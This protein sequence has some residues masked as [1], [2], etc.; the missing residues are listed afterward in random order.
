MNMYHF[1]LSDLNKESKYVGPEGTKN[2][3]D[4][5]SRE[6]FDKK[7]TFFCSDIVLSKQSSTSGRYFH[8]DNENS[9]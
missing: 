1:D 5:F 2:V 7:P 3:F 4:F 8:I 9:F 6:D